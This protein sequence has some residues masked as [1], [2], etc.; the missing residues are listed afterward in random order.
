LP[1]SYLKG[2]PSQLFVGILNWMKMCFISLHN[3]RLCV[4]KSA[5]WFCWTFKFCF[6][7]L[8]NAGG[9]NRDL[10]FLGII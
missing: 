9:C 6:Y 4:W 5:N 2:K 1:S 10:D 3:I 7:Q 8:R